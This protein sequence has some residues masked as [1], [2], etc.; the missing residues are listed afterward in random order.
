MTYNSDRLAYILDVMLKQGYYNY[1]YAFKAKGDSVPDITEVEGMHFETE[2]DYMILVYDR[3]FGDDY[4]HLIGY[5]Q[6]N[7]LKKL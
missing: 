6:F 4:D 5:I 1:V 2:N 3:P 7:S